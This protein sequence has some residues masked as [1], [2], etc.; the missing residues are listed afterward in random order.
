MKFV[1]EDHALQKRKKVSKMEIL[2]RSNR[3]LAVRMI[4]SELNLN[5]ETSQHFN[6]E[7]GMRNY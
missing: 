3:P 4:G 6:L 2:I 5:Y 7:F 1:L